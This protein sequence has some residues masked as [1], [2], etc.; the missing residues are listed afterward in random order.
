MKLLDKILLAQDFSEDSN[1]VVENA[2]VLAKVFQS[3]VVPIHVLP[4]NIVNEKAKSLLHE[5]ALKRLEETVNTIKSSGAK[6]GAPLLEFGSA[7]DEI[8]RAS[9]NINANIIITGAGEIKKGSRYPLG[10]TTARIIQ[11]SE[12]PVLVVKHGEPLEVSHILCPVDFSEPSKRALKNAIVIARRFNAELTII[13]VCEL[14]GA[15][16][17]ASEKEIDKE[18]ELRYALHKDEF[19]AFL[20]GFS[21]TDVNW[22][23]EM[24]K[25]NPEEEIHNTISRKKT[26]LVI[27][28]ASGKSGLSRMIIGSVTEK[29]VRDVP[30]SFLILKSEDAISLQL[31]TNIRDIEQLHETAMKLMKDGFY[32]EAIGQ[33]KASLNINDM[34]V[35]S[36]QALAKIHDKL[37]QPEKAQMYRN[38]AKDIMDK[39]WYTKIEEEVRKLRGS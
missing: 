24:P 20:K 28:G 39:V 18:N 34:H 32:E 16:W 7:S 19:N 4:K 29:V 6:A 21:L 23:K 31:E 33:L 10:T 5:T 9:M 2:M 26:D 14:Q 15:T 1:T 25:G 3:E 13:A 35:P 36:Y 11:K 17:F 22:N 8:V 12:K 27:M 37:K 38:N 30:C